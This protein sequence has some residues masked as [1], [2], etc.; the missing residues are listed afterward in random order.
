QEG[1]GQVVDAVLRGAEVHGDVGGGGRP[2]ERDDLRRP[3]QH[4]AEEAEEREREE[5]S[6][7]E[8]GRCAQ[9]GHRFGPPFLGG[10]RDHPDG[11]RVSMSSHS[12]DTY[13][14]CTL[15]VMPTLWHATMA[16][17]RRGVRDAILHTAAALVAERGLHAV[18][19]SEI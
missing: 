18:T 13:P 2:E 9:R 1:E 14:R 17:H 19:M 8:G 10:G 16:A 15:A 5:Q 7:R 4:E 11:D 12:V 3:E 6:Q